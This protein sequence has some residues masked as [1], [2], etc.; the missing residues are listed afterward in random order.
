M[1]CSIDAETLVARLWTAPCF[2]RQTAYVWRRRGE[3]GAR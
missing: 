3:Q 1:D 2:G